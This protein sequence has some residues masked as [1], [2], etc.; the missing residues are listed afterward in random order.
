MSLDSRRDQS[1]VKAISVMSMV[2]LPATFFCGVFNLPF[3][4]WT[5][6]RLSEVVLNWR[7]WIYVACVVGTTLI[8]TFFWRVW[9]RFEKWRLSHGR[10][11][12]VRRDLKSWVKSGFK[13]ID[14]HA[15]ALRE[16]RKKKL[17]LEP[18]PSTP[19]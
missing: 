10:S 15:Q 13:Q 8:I 16:R 1:A 12:N 17:L 3:F 7:I 6:N 11:K 18:S 5:A 2:F 4:D 9:F 14:K 19:V